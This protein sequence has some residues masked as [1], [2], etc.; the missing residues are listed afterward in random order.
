MATIGDENYIKACQGAVRLR[1]PVR[2]DQRNGRNPHLERQ[3]SQELL[4]KRAT[5]TPVLADALH[6][7]EGSDDLEA[8]FSIMIRTG[9]RLVRLQV[10]ECISSTGVPS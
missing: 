3:K 2:H 7:P 4:R 10:V 5:R 8:P 6:R 1:H 9:A